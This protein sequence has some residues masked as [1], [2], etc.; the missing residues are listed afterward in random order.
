MGRMAIV[1]NHQMT[2]KQAT[3]RCLIT[4]SLGLADGQLSSLAEVRKRPLGTLV[5][6]LDPGGPKHI[7]APDSAIDLF[8]YIYRPILELPT[9]SCNR[10]RNIT[11][12]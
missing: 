12:L 11:G 2:D 6:C 7:V 5:V 8:S 1:I 4:M 10:Q 9:R 3:S